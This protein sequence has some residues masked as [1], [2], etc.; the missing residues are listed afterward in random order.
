MRPV[1]QLVTG[2]DPEN[3]IWGDCLRACIA[4]LFE[5]EPEEVPHF[6]DETLHP[7]GFYRKAQEWLR[8]RDMTM[9]AYKI[10]ADALAPM[11][12]SMREHGVDAFHL[13]SGKSGTAQHVLVA[14]YCEPVHDPFPKTDSPW[15]GQLVP[16]DEGNYELMFIVKRFI[17]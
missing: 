2:L 13:L 5:M 14:R 16:D 1:F 15:Y 3:N 11:G 7:E 6:A 17:N 10:P 8:E 12:V 9:I 4:S